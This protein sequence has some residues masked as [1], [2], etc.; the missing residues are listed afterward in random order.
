MAR[1]KP[2]LNG[3]ILFSS[4]SQDNERLLKEELFSCYK[5]IGI[6]FEVLEKMPVRDRKFYIIKHNLW[7]EG[8]NGKAPNQHIEGEMLNKYT[9]MS[10]LNEKNLKLRN[11]G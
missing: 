8:E 1:L 5:H 4:I 10:Q 7:A 3:T 2:F 11:G 9:E 6:P